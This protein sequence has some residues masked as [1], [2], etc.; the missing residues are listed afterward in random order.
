MH[1]GDKFSMVVFRPKVWDD[2]KKLGDIKKNNSAAKAENVLSSISQVKLF[3]EVAKDFLKNPSTI[4][5]LRVQNCFQ[6]GQLFS[7]LDASARHSHVDSNLKNS[8]DDVSH[9]L[10]NDPATSRLENIRLSRFSKSHVQTLLLHIMAKASTLADQ[11]LRP[12]G[13]DC[14]QLADQSLFLKPEN[15]HTSQ[16]QADHEY[17]VECS[18][19]T[20]SSLANILEQQLHRYRICLEDYEEVSNSTHL[21][22]SCHL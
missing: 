14:H 22:T 2:H 13:L 1:C 15:L 4:E 10:S 16:F 11:A 21:T 5:D 8:N 12:N 19:V 18:D 20:F 7:V 9:V 3:A 6:N 17:S